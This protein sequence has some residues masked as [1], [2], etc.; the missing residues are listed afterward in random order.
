M[1]SIFDLVAILLTVS[2]AFAFINAKLLRLPTTIG[3]MI[4][5][6]AASLTLIGLELLTAETQLS[7][8]LTDAVR[9]IDF[10]EG[11]RGKTGGG[12]NLRFTGGHELD[13]FWE[14]CRPPTSMA[15][16]MPI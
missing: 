1:L 15:Y 11:K 13:S 4:M 7:R 5:G 9:Q 12:M 14:C 16:R 6:L 8:A 2:A 3:V 10:T